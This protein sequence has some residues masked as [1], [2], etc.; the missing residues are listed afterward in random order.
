MPNIASVLKSEISRVPRKEVR[1]ETMAVKKAVGGYRAEIAALKRRMQALEQDVR[2]LS[3]ASAK[4]APVADEVPSRT[5]RFTAKG[6]AAQ[7]KRLELSAADCGLLVGAS[8]QSVNNWEDRTT[9]P[10]PKLLPAIAALRS[11]GKKEAAARLSELRE[12]A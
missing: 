5:I 4:N 7:R 9:Q 1:G 3:K 8:G 6:F 2:R 11:M 12:A 10:R